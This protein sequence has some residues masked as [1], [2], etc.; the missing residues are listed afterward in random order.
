MAE[1]KTTTDDNESSARIEGEAASANADVDVDPELMQLP[2]QRRRRR[3]HPLIALVVISLSAFLLWFTWDDLA[4]FL[5]SR[6]PQDVGQVTSALTQGKLG[7]NSHVTLHGAPDRKYALILEGRMGGYDSFFPLLEASN[8]VF[9]QRHRE[10]RSTEQAITTTHTG[11]LIWFDRLPGAND[12]RSY[13]AKQGRAVTHDLPFD[14]VRRA[15]AAGGK[16]ATLNDV[17]GVPVQV[18]PDSVVWVNVTFPDEWIVQF[19]KQVTPKAPAAEEQLKDLK[20][21]FAADDESSTMFWRFVVHAAPDQLPVLMALRGRAKGVEV[22]PRHLAFRAR[23]NQLRASAS[24]LEIDAADP[25]FSP[26]FR[27]SSTD[28]GRLVPVKEQ[29]VKL[30]RS[31][32]R[33][34]ETSSSFTVG[35]DAVVLIAGVA[36]GDKWPYLVLYV[37]LI[38]FIILNTVSLVLRLRDRSSS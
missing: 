34:I 17:A 38:G 8:R 31:A 12:L 10:R 20:L 15:L 9:V 2:R 19:R 32:I 21:P 24:E 18:G 14:K 36:P 4:Y 6:Q 27:V 22:V 30:P 3:R 28:E 16:R 5:A 23:W 11:Q 7:H 1:D 29:P 25:S 13:L 33:Y 37:L 26:R 35:P